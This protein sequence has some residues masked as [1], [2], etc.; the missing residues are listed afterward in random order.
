M[1]LFES[2][3]TLEIIRSDDTKQFVEKILAERSKE[4]T[5]NLLTIVG[6][7][8]ELQKLNPVSLMGCAIKAAALN[9]PVDP[10]LGL[11]YIVG[12]GGSATLQLGYKG[13]I[14]LA[15]RSGK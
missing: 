9:L 13:Y 4:F 5:S 1:S 6:G 14:Q 3:K 2:S 11:A 15:I 12:F 10:Q 8:P 7:N